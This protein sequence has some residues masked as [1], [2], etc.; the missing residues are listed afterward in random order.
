MI[1][2]RE[3]ALAVKRALATGTIALCGAGSLTAFATQATTQASATQVTAAKTGAAKITAK[4]V[5]T[6][7][8]IVLA[9]ATTVPQPA[10][11]STTP[12]PVLQT[13]V[14][15]GTM[16]A[17]PALETSEA[18]TVVSAEAIKDQGLVNVEQT[19]DQLTSNVP[20][21]NVAQSVSTYTGGGSY[22]NLRGLGA[23]HTL[24]LLDGQRL[25]NN[26][27]AGNSV[28]LNGI[29][30]SAIDSVQV[31]REGASSLYGSDAIGGVINFITKKDYQ[32]AEVDLD[33][34]RPQ[35]T[36]GASGNAS[37]SLG[38]GD[39]LSDGYNFMIT[40]S[41][42]KQ[43]EL[44]AYQRSFAA[45]GFDPSRGLMNQNGPTATWPASYFDANGS[46]WQVGYPQCAGNPELTEY[47]GNCAYL[48]SAVVDLLPKSDETSGLAAFTKELPDN[49][50]LSIQYFYTRSSVT[51]WTGPQSYSFTMDPSSPYYPTAAESTC[52]GTCA[53]A[54]PALGGPITVG[55]S[56]PN[57]NRYMGDINTEQRVLLTFS[58]N[59]AGWDYTTSLDYS[60]NKN[61]LDVDGGEADYSIIAPGNVLSPLINPFGPYSAAANQL[62]NSA[63]MNGPLATGKLQHYDL[64]GHASHP[65]GDA[66]NAGRDATLAL[67]F[68]ATYESISYASTPLAQTLYTATYYPPQAISGSRNAYAVFSELDVPVSKHLDVDL[69]DREDRYS[70]FG[71]TNNGKL[72]VRY[73]PVKMLT[74]RGAA[75]TGFRAPS[76]IDLY[77]PDIFGADA[78]TMNGPPC[79]SGAYTA[80][81]TYTNCTSQGLSLTGGNNKLQ[82]ETSE[83]FDVG[84]I[85]APVTNLGITLDYYRILIKN[86]IQGIPDNVIYANPDQFANDYVLNSS[87]T[88]TPAPLANTQCPTYTAP[89]CGYV[90]QT[91]QNTGGITTDGFDVSVQYFL[92]TPIGAFHADLEGTAI[93][94]YRLQ[95][96]TGGPQVDLLGWYNGGNQPAIRWQHDLMLT[97]TSPNHVWGAGIT[98]RF[99]SSYIDEYRTDGF[100]SGSPDPSGAPQ[101][102][103]GSDSTWDVY[104]S[105]KPIRPLTVLFGIRNV[106]DKNPPFSNQT[107]NWPAGY[108][109]IF[110]SP[111]L[112]TFYVNLKYQIF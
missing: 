72:A 13:V 11:T 91:T 17:R 82:P 37:F 25:A 21:V 62:I 65:L 49:N 64:G 101:L 89:T 94:H 66:F 84:I 20:G 70:D 87:G 80:V 4:A 68:D 51:T 2:N 40:G 53:T 28:D 45:T 60:V 88:L 77:Q 34:D 29:P 76:L 90:I 100:P 35:E 74:F 59:N 19:V 43:Q 73:Q 14:V 99:F 52:Y 12:T 9:Q 32:G 112:R 108:N 79:G 78:G 15:T 86:E 50:Q 102:K 107:S 27:V 61:T 81:F 54:T 93:T 63:Y 7:A 75:S 6:K 83:N 33:V 36:G 104:T 71:E 97:W 23:S 31:L 44:K 24:V 5:T 58:G 55:W 38:H 10:T 111:L 1:T 47:F 42:S 41:Y 92:R 39:L 8:P 95:E 3:L 57:N 67:G 56:D 110:S 69:S 46:L 85:V 109:P 26:V 105:F 96:F 18:V 16:I 106:L 98:N 22:A 48:Y 30:F 103:V